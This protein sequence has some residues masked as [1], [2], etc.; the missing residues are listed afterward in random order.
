MAGFLFDS[1]A[2]DA[3]DQFGLT[4]AIGSHKLKGRHDA[5]TGDFGVLHALSVREAVNGCFDWFGE[6][7][8]VLSRAG[9]AHNVF[10]AFCG[11]AVKEL[12]PNGV[13]CEG[14][15]L[16]LA[17]GVWEELGHRVRSRSSI[18]W[19]CLYL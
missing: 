5:S 15:E 14:S 11:L 12:L 7:F 18:V 17:G 1:D 16:Y 6:H 8:R 3:L 13:R 2:L 19:V 4:Q 9:G 10:G